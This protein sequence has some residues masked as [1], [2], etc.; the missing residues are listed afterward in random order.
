MRHGLFRIQVL[1]ESCRVF[2][3]RIVDG[4]TALEADHGVTY[5]VIIRVFLINMESFPPRKL[6]LV[7]T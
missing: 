7:Y 5:K 6:G 2:P 3:E 1:S 4:Q